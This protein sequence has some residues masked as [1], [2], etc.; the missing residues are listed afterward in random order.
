MSAL[1]RRV[2]GRKRVSTV[3]RSSWHTTVS[4]ISTAIS[5]LSCPSST[6]GAS[7]AATSQKARPRIDVSTT[8][9]MRL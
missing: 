9:A 3:P 4:T 5:A 8:L 6:G 2:T 7:L 1:L